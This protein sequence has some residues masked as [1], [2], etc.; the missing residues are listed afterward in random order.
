MRKTLKVV[1]VEQVEGSKHYKD[2]SSG[3]YKFQ[4]NFHME[5]GSIIV[6]TVAG[7]RLK[8]AKAILAKYQSENGCVGRYIQDLGDGMISHEYRHG[9]Y[10]DF[11]KNRI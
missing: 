2:R 3:Y 4:C 10:M 9:E 1:K 11:M 8:D 6:S 7:Q 5:D